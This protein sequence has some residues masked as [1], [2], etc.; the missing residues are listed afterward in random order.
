MYM[1][2]TTV[3]NIKMENLCMFVSFSVKIH[4]NLNEKTYKPIPIRTR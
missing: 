1:L 4:D 3:T 2:H